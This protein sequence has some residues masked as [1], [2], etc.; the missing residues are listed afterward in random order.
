[1]KR[2]R[3]IVAAAVAATFLS[4]VGGVDPGEVAVG[5]GSGLVDSARTELSRG[6]FWHATRLLRSAGVEQEPGSVLLLARAEAGWGNWVEAARLL[7][8][9][10]LEA[11]KDGG[12]AW[13]L[14]GRAR[15]EAER[16]REAATAYD[17]FLET[18]PSG[19][20]QDAVRGRA[21]R[22]RARAGDPLGALDLLDGLSPD[23]VVV[24]SWVILEMAAF[25]AEQG[26]TAQ[27]AALL[28]RIVDGEAREASWRLL[29]EARLAVGDSTGAEEEYRS[30]MKSNPTARRV[31]AGLAVGR[32]ALAR[33][34][35]ATARPLLL[36]GLDA[37]S[38]GLRAL[39]A[40]DL[41]AI[42]DT[43]LALTVRL[44]RLFDRVGDGRRALR[45]YDLAAA[46]AEEQGTPLA[47]SARL[48]RVRLMGTVVHRQDEALEEHRAIRA[49][50]E[51]RTLGARNLEVWAQ[52]RRRQG[53]SAEVETLRRWLVEEFPESSQAA[54]VGWAK[55]FDAESRGNGTVALRH[56][57]DV[58]RDAPAHTRAGQ[59]RMRIGQIL[60][61]QGRL[62][63]ATAVFQ[64]YLADF[65]DGRRWEEASFWA[66]WTTL[67]NGDRDAASR[68][69]DRILS[70]SPVSYYAVVGSE[71]LGRPFAVSLP[72]GPI[73]VEAGWLTDGLRRLDL[74]EAA[75]L[76]RGAAAE[77]RRLVA[78]AGLSV[79][80][81]LSLAEALI[82]RGRTITGINLGWDL[83]A[84]GA[85][86]TRRLLQVL[87][88]FPY[89]ELVRM[90]AEEWGV[91]P[92][93]LA[94]I[95]RQ[96][97]AFKADIVSRAGAVGL[98]QVMPPTGRELAQT[99]GP[100]GFR[101]VSLATPEVNLHLGAAF[102]VD[103]RRRY[104]DLPLVLS[105]YNAGPTRATRWKRYPE[106]ADP[107]RFTE[108][109][110]FEETRGYV[111][112]VRR[113]IG[114]YRALYAQDVPPAT[115]EEQR[116]R[117]L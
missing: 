81:T 86:W 106:A 17:R 104:G 110:P 55:G 96:E 58:A 26:D 72:E 33:G 117:T 25:V 6:R 79:D 32:L 57:A 7:D 67:R 109:I 77:E 75:G 70:D 102:F 74:L 46:L 34:D 35:S 116:G 43:D 37:P 108:R 52:L 80:L 31:E 14:L 76:G 41:L 29:P 5:A 13:F 87:Y 10:A 97:S 91:D 44:A 15:E 27:V 45:A 51:D 115:E 54:E 89:E 93:T 94:A 78:K 49:E 19:A 23:G 113:N 22:A 65:P 112:N 39:A 53:R 12:E 18:A 66:A 11:G 24:A 21:A 68:F 101:E 85:P 114:L 111:K 36:A 82:A 59:A 30:A 2:T 3:P 50:A 47:G 20:E 69:V 105:A 83:L 9:A 42:G 62:D 95:I 98:M 48:A 1:M 56:Y 73:P 60:I 61:Q 28:P 40:A 8:G 38:P 4:V 63:E 64:D 84:A 103:M 99:H 107:L 92:V 16:W 90:E 100:K 88:P 71:L